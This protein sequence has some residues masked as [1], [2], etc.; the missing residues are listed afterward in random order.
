MYKQN[1]NKQKK[2]CFA[3]FGRF[4]PTSYGTELTPLFPYLRAGL[5]KGGGGNRLDRMA[6]FY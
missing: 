5:L 4:I 3:S 2:L 1:K 6:G